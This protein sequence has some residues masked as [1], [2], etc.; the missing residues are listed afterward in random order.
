MAE[1]DNPTL[2]A[3]VF[4]TAGVLV[5]RQAMLLATA[6]SDRLTDMGNAPRSCRTVIAALGGSRMKLGTRNQ[7]KGRIIAEPIGQTTAHLRLDIGSVIAISSITNAAL[8]DLDLKVGAEASN[9]VIAK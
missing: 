1:H 5:S 2:F 7:L 8:D 4:A 6:T 9:V 3:G